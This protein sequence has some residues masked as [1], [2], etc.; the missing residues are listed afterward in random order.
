[1]R[2]AVRGYTTDLVRAMGSSGSS[3]TK[4][5]VPEDDM[6]AAMRDAV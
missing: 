1:M 2:L 3:A 6:D 5:G 4:E